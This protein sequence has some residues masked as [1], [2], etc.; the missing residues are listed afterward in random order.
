MQLCSFVEGELGE[1]CQRVKVIAR[2]PLNLGDLRG[3]ALSKPKKFLR[4]FA[5]FDLP[6]EEVWHLIERI[7]YVRNVMVH[8]AGFAWR[9]RNDNH[10]VGFAAVAPGL[11]LD[12]D[13]IEL[14]REFCDYCLSTISDF[15]GQLHEAYEC[16]RT[17]SQ[18][19]ELATHI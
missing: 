4:A 19:S 12:N 10:I 17:V 8:E 1:I 9:N 2:V 14:N 3:S 7:F 13:H 18:T 15:C 11:K 6:S 16:F 5:N